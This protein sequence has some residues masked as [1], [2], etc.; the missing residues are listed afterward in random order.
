MK[1]SLMA[2]GLAL[3]V[4]V[5]GCTG[6]SGTTTTTPAPTGPFTDIF[7]SIIYPGDVVTH[8]FAVTATGTVT[9]TLTNAGPPAT[10]VM[11]LGIG[12]PNPA[13]PGCSLTTAVNTSAGSTPQI[14]TTANNG[15]YCIAIFD[16]GNNIPEGESFSITIVHP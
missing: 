15:F 7:T 3:L 1:R 12:V 9:V 13:G 14:T 5:G 10:V 16:V 8:S 6:D 4:L 11:G 2:I